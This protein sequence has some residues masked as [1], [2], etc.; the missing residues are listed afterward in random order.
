MCSQALER[1]TDFIDLRGQLQESLIGDTITPA[2]TTAF[3]ELNDGLI[4]A[5]T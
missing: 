2:Y 3:L 4:A 5:T 1:F